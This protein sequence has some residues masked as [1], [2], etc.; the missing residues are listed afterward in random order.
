MK[1][2]PR[3]LYFLVQFLLPYLSRTEFCFE[4]QG[5]ILYNQVLIGHAYKNFLTRG[6][7]NCGQRCLADT[8]CV[9][10]NYQTSTIK[11]GVCELNEKRI[12]AKE[13]FE[14][15]QGFAFVRMR[16]RTVGTVLVLSSHLNSILIACLESTQA[17]INDQLTPREPLK[18]A[19]RKTWQFVTF[20]PFN[21]SFFIASN[22]IFTLILMSGCFLASQTD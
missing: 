22:Q 9:S 13:L 19:S 11:D 6:I 20:R 14:E 16:R 4:S 15:K 7:F 21:P 17:V 10:Y 12:E 5:S 18:L 8:R 1:A 2:T 3:T